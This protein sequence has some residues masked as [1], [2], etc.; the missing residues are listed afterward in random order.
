M[1]EH[2]RG[3]PDCLTIVYGLDWWAAYPPDTTGDDLR[4][5]EPYLLTGLGDPSSEALE[6]A[7]RIYLLWSKMEEAT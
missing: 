1:N 4:A 2:D 6:A 7:W 3:G 5:G